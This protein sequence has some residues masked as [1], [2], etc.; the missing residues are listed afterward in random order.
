MRNNS[1]D[2]SHGSVNENTGF[3]A[4]R[5]LGYLF[6][7]CDDVDGMKRFYQ[8]LFQFKIEMEVPGR[9]VEF[10][11]GS[12][13]L[14]LRSRGRQYDGP[15]ISNQSAA[16]QLSFR[17]PPSDVDI[18]YDTL[19]AMDVD[20]IEAPTNQDWPHRTLYF[21]DPESNILEIFAD[22]HI[23]ETASAPTGVHALVEK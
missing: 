18:A 1:V 9:M 16:L 17:V 19:K 4:V 7:L 3:G 8:A 6:I 14:G 20:V 12:L 22:I 13:F 10:R 21:R 15:A 5:D 23:Q 11:L 2:Q